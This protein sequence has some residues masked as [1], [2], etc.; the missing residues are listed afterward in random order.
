M[1]YGKTK[2]RKQWVKDLISFTCVIIASFIM[3][4]NIRT[5]VRA[6]DLFPGGFTGLTVLI[7]R[8]CETYL[9]FT[10]PYTLVNVGLNAVPAYISLKTI[11]KRFTFFSLMMVCLSSIF[12][13][14]LPSSLAV[15][16]DRFLVAL[17][18]GMI[19]G[20]GI[21]IALHGRASS[22][23]TDFIAVYLNEKLN[24]PSWN[25]VF[26]INACMLTVAGLL[27]GWDAALYSIV[28]QFVS[29]QMINYVHQNY[30]RVTLH[31]ITSYPEELQTA[32]LNFTHHGIT[33]FEGIG[34][35]KNEARTMLYSVVAKDEVK[36]VIKF[37]RTY[38]PNAFINV[39]KSESI[40]GRFYK[41]PLN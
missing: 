31:I 2:N 40:H 17:F 1:V 37:I 39:T 4:L 33:R 13:D 30:T 9:N 35:Y 25:V 24:I 15:T 5:F 3:A 6:G 23:G 8:I 29:T 7:Q 38:D 22:G 26:G 34:C 21:G 20:L 41:D 12:V 14:C 32:L 19:N 36:D 28:Y 27:F 11:G 10:I 16:S 18:G